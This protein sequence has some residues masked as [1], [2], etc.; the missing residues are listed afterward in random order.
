MPAT[1]SEF[2]EV[3]K[4]IAPLHYAEPWDNVGLLVG[5]QISVVHQAMLTIDFTEEILTEAIENN[6][7]LIITYHPVMFHP[8]KSITDADLSG[9][10]LLRAMRHGINIYSPHTALDAAAGGVTDWLSDSVGTGYRRP[11]VPQV[12]HSEEN[13]IKLVTFVPKKS[14][15]RV[16]DALTSAGAG[17]IG[18]YEQCSFNVSG[19]AT[20]RGNMESNPAVGT[21]GHLEEVEEI[22]LEMVCPSYAIG[23][24]VNTLRQFHPYEE[25]AFD[26]Y[27]LHP[28]LSHNTG[29]GRKVVLDQASN[30]GE[31]AQR[32]KA[33][34]KIPSIKITDPTI[35][36][37]AI[38]LIPGAGSAVLDT[39]I[40]QGCDLFV[41]GEMSHHNAL[42]AEGRGC[43]VILTGHTN[44]ERGYMPILS[45][46]LK[47]LLSDV[48]F[49]ISTKDRSRFSV[50]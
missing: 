32:I 4:E 47:S 9:R 23:L 15:V 39:A 37:K 38:G 24:I 43:S 27:P 20:F 49:I 45:S 12:M 3:M 22:R 2:I 50:Q 33:H 10:I 11:L 48:D 18:Q 19:T 29:V 30:V 13:D 21:P 35:P 14:L 6:V 41:T 31:I 7:E 44:S 28:A 40:E 25:P 8:T 1:V 17:K 42:S 26:L 16:R 46:R 34:L 5:T 36:V